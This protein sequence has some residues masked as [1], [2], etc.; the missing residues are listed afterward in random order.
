MPQVAQLPSEKTKFILP[1]GMDAKS[2]PK[3][4]TAEAGTSAPDDKVYGNVMRE[5]DAFSQGQPRMLPAEVPEQQANINEEAYH[6][7]MVE[8]TFEVAPELFGDEHIEKLMRIDEQPVSVTRKMLE[9]V[10]AAKKA[11]ATNGFR[12]FIS[13]VFTIASPERLAGAK[14]PD[15]QEAEDLGVRAAVDAMGGYRKAKEYFEANG[16]PFPAHPIMLTPDGKYL[17]ELQK[18]H[19]RE[20]GTGMFLAKMT[21]AWMAIEEQAQETSAEIMEGGTAKRAMHGVFTVLPT[22]GASVFMR[23]AR[24][25]M[26]TLAAAGGDPLLVARLGMPSKEEAITAR[27]M[28]LNKEWY[29]NQPKDGLYDRTIYKLGEM[30]YDIGQ[31]SME[32]AAYLAMVQGVTGAPYAGAAGPQATFLQFAGAT[33]KQSVK[34]AL[35]RMLTE[36]G[37]TEERMTGGAL[38]FIYNM[39]PVTSREFGGFAGHVLNSQTMGKITAVGVDILS[40]MGIS[41]ASQDLYRTAFQS[42]YQQAHVEG[43][44]VAEA[45]SWGIY[46]ALAVAPMDVL[47]SLSTVPKQVAAK[48]AKS[49]PAAIDPVVKQTA[50]DVD[51]AI[52][53]RKAEPKMAVKIEPTPA[54]VE[55]LGLQEVT[56]VPAEPPKEVAVA[57]TDFTAMSW[58]ELRA[59]AKELGIPV[60]GN[61]AALEAAVQAKMGKAPAE[62]PAAAEAPKPE[63]TPARAYEIVREPVGISTKQG[64]QEVKLIKSLPFLNEYEIKKDVRNDFIQ[65][66]KEANTAKERKAIEKEAKDSLALR[67]TQIEERRKQISKQN[68]DAF[69]SNPRKAVDELIKEG[70]LSFDLGEMLLFRG[71]GNVTSK[72]T[73]K[74]QVVGKG[75]DFSYTLSNYRITAQIGEH[76]LVKEIGSANNANDVRRAQSFVVGTLA[77]QIA[78]SVVREQVAPA[79][80]TV[81]SAESK[82]PELMSPEE[83]RALK[84][85]RDREAGRAII[86]ERDDIDAFGGDSQEAKESGQR[87]KELSEDRWVGA[88]PVDVLHK[89]SLRF[90]IAANKPV[91]ATAVDTYGIKLPEGYVRDGDRYVFKGEG[92]P[93]PDAAAEQPALPDADLRTI[94]DKPG[95]SH[96]DRWLGGKGGWFGEDGNFHVGEPTEGPLAELRAG[97]TPEQRMAES[98]AD[99]WERW[100]QQNIAV[101]HPDPVEKDAVEAGQDKHGRATMQGTTEEIYRQKEAAEAVMRE[102]P[103]VRFL[104]GAGYKVSDVKMTAHKNSAYLDVT[105]T[106]PLADAGM[107]RIRVSDH[108]SS[109]HTAARYA[110]DVEVFIGKDLASD[111]KEV[112]KVLRDPET[113]KKI[114]VAAG[115]KIAANVVIPEFYRRGVKPRQPGIINRIKEWFGYAEQQPIDAYDAFTLKHWNEAG[116]G[117]MSRILEHGDL[118]ETNGPLSR[119]W[120]MF[121]EGQTRHDRFLNTAE[122]IINPAFDAMP[123]AY[124]ST[125]S[126]DMVSI[127]GEG[128]FTKLELID[129]YKLSKNAKGLRC[130]K[131]GVKI[132][133]NM[134]AAPVKFTDE[135]IADLQAY[136]ESDKHLSFAVKNGFDKALPYAAGEVNA[137]AR[138]K[139]GHDIA[140]DPDYWMIE[141]DRAGVLKTWDSIETP[142]DLASATRAIDLFHQANNLQARNESD[143][144]VVVGNSVEKFNKYMVSVAR[145]VGFAE[146]V[147]AARAIYMSPEFRAFSRDTFS[148]ATQ[149]YIEEYFADIEAGGTRRTGRESDSTIDNAINVMNQRRTAVGLKNSARAATYQTASYPTA[150]YSIPGKHFGQG[151]L[152]GELPE[153]T[154]HMSK[155][156]PIMRRRFKLSGAMAEDFYAEGRGR[157]GIGWKPIY[158]MDAKAI[159]MIWND[160]RYWA[161]ALFPS[162]SGDALEAKTGELTARVTAQTQ[163]SS[164]PMDRPSLARTSNPLVRGLLVLFSSQ[165]NTNAG[166]EFL[167]ESQMLNRL[168]TGQYWQKGG[169]ALIK[170]DV[171]KL[172]TARMVPKVIITALSTAGTAATMA[173]LK[174]QNIYFDEDEDEE[175][176]AQKMATTLLLTAIADRGMF[177]SFAVKLAS[178]M[179][180][181]AGIDWLGAGQSISGSTEEFN[182]RAVDMFETFGFEGGV[183]KQNEK[184]G[185]KGTDKADHETAVQLY[186]I[187]KAADFVTGIGFMNAIVQG[188]GLY[189]ILSGEADDTEAQRLWKE[190]YQRAKE[191]REAREE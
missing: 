50:A 190:H 114:E 84:Q 165:K 166:N 154:E 121:L 25:M 97:M 132:K 151:L 106:G 20:L 112:E 9:D 41:E 168:K 126:K 24:G 13:D 43:L 65:K 178:S 94:A 63:P 28:Q 134:N 29:G 169:G 131:I 76:V 98:P 177:M 91:S 148:P 77:K 75:T 22:A 96:G 40:N 81:E 184:Y 137:V 105:P 6:R 171:V 149:K 1:E 17:K 179:S 58:N 136:V 172:F 30:S 46:R 153:S 191:R 189:A 150:R 10:Y 129:L 170:D 101:N 68:T 159:G 108:P 37:S 158:Y 19:G 163:P 95:I 180:S 8:S 27:V 88:T 115:R 99:T 16:Q 128:K 51:T 59:V 93:K 173:F 42:G 36:P 48:M 44:G 167:H 79:A 35:F 182:K 55:K 138:K 164:N 73:G 32:A 110:P 85:S 3:G 2:L 117:F 146:P 157:T 66:L 90:A 5:L 123:K 4:L 100:N 141:R 187:G 127:R 45:M 33:G 47:P 87:A 156:N 130:I 139:I 116:F 54:E 11:P 103:D 107:I 152:H 161:K 80:K 142:S 23:T 34:F 124:G 69:L 78:A 160:C 111:P 89:D 118:N 39:T 53:D 181:A 18:Q 176:K 26:Q 133:R 49:I 64:D 145:Y 15:R 21:P 186:A 113:L 74:G 72:R 71:I 86:E 12:A 135:M 125:K 175:S 56:P 82:P 155:H 140:V 122:D 92:E 57:G 102:R 143:G 162:L 83:A 67:K 14:T 120:E 174:S 119:P 147:D 183:R 109:E 70:G 52:A 7:A 31:G 38:A 62:A 185:M 61:R 60:K 188:G 104:E 144:V